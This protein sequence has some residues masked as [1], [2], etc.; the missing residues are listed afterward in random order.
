MK[1]LFSFFPAF[2]PVVR[3]L[4]VEENEIFVMHPQFKKMLGDLDIATTSIDDISRSVSGLSDAGVLYS[5][6]CLKIAEKLGYDGF[7][8]DYPT[9]I[10][11]YMNNKITVFLYN[12]LPQVATLMA[13]VDYISP[14][15]VVLH[16][17][18]EPLTR[19]V[20]LWAQARRIPCLHVPHAVYLNAGRGVAGTDV[21]DLITASHLAA[22][23]EYQKEWYVERGF[24]P[25]KIRITGL[26]NFDKMSKVVP[27]KGR[28]RHLLGIDGDG[29]VITYASS[30]RQD[31]NLLGCHDG[32]ETTTRMVIAAAKALPEVKLIIKTHPNGRD[33]DRHARLAK[34][35]GL[36][37]IVTAHHL[38][39]VLQASDLVFSYGPSNLLMEAAFIPWVR[40]MCTNGYDD[41]E[42]ITLKDEFSLEDLVGAWRGSLSVRPP[43]YDKFI[44]KYCGPADGQAFSRVVEYIS[45]LGGGNVE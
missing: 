34:E 7:Y 38:T 16:N 44:K 12:R 26:L 21:H 23:G 15:V 41:S 2:I 28:A 42:I 29:P 43:K 33:V 25:E 40:L 6:E 31:T 37:C 24:D 14:D 32:V 9:S 5:Y 10:K 13:V 1:I 19:I 35:S 8:D 4:A 17:D 39:T 20:A 3:A 27:N 45:D 18:V 30:W 11:E 22:S 36:D